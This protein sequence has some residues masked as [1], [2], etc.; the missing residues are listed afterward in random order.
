MCWLI[1]QHADIK[2]YKVEREAVM[3]LIQS[4]C[5]DENIDDFFGNNWVLI[6]FIWEQFR[7]GM[8]DI[9][10]SQTFWVSAL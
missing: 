10:T 2:H 9:S 6:I 5:R 3:R 4:W 1:D 8:E 7:G